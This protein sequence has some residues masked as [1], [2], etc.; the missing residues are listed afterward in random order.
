MRYAS[1]TLARYRARGRWNGRLTISRQRSLLLRQADP[2]R[3]QADGRADLWRLTS[4]RLRGAQ[5][6]LG[7]CSRRQQQEPV[8][9]A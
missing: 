5:S 8:G 7:G 1:V 4:R 3:S 6:H 2:E 9:Y